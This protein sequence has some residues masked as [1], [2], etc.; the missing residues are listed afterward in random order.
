MKKIAIFVLLWAI[1]LYGWN[2]DLVGSWLTEYDSNICNLSKSELE[3]FGSDYLAA[4]ETKLNTYDDWINGSIFKLRIKEYPA[5]GTFTLKRYFYAKN[6][7][8]DYSVFSLWFMLKITSKSYITALYSYVPSYNYRTYYDEDSSGYE[9]C[10]YAV[11]KFKVEVRRKF[12]QNYQLNLALRYS[13]YYY[14]SAFRE[15][16]S[17][18]P[19]ISISLERETPSLFSKLELSYA[20]RLARGYDSQQE[21]KK[22][23]DENDI[24]YHQIAVGWQVAKPVG[25]FKIAATTSYEHNIYTTKKEDT[26][27]KDR[28]EH[29]IM[30]SLIH[31]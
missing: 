28:T 8:K 26:L 18:K 13:L 30:L 29:I 14:N 16:D 24:S 23:S 6:P 19:G 1:P 9:W 11:N 10:G 17:H 2:I 5:W 12:A 22:I 15:Y 4:Q 31:I 25:N 21:V 27:H 3:E 20:N 7:I